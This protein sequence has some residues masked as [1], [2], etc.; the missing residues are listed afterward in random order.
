MLSTERD[1][2]QRD[3]LKKEKELLDDTMKAWL[4]N[5]TAQYLPF[6]N[7]PPYTPSPLNPTQ[8]S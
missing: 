1:S 7:P 4:E 2:T 5:I 6:L 8:K 3:A